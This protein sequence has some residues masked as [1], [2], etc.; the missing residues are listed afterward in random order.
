MEMHNRLNKQ[1]ASIESDTLSALPG[2]APVRKAIVSF[3]SIK[4]FGGWK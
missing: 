4:T 2:T 3:D 1:E